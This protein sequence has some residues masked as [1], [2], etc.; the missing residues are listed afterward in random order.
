MPHVLG[1]RA[2]YL[3]ATALGG[4]P[5]SAVEVGG[6]SGMRVGCTVGSAVG[7]AVASTVFG[8][9]LVVVD[10]D[11]AGASVAGVETGRALRVSVAVQAVSAPRGTTARKARRSTVAHRNGRNG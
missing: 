5:A 6:E 4:E 10:V 8:L 11:D 3:A 7:S 2:A 1:L 9:L